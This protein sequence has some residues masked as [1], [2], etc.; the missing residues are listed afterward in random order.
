MNVDRVNE[1]NVSQVKTN[2]LPITVFKRPASEHRKS[3]LNYQRFNEALN[4]KEEVYCYLCGEPRGD[5]VD[6]RCRSCGGPLT[7]QHENTFSIQRIATTRFSMWRYAHALAPSIVCAPVSLGEGC[8]P[9]VNAIRSNIWM[10]LEHVMPTLSFKD[11]GSAA[12]MSYVRSFAGSRN[13]RGVS[14]DSSGNAGASIAAYAS[15]AGL[16]CRIFAPT[17]ISEHKERQI[18]ALGA[19]LEKLSGSRELITQAATSADSGFIYVGHAWNP[20]FIEGIKTL[21]YELAE[22][23]RWNSPDVIYVPVSA[24][25]ILLGVIYGF[26]HLLESG[27]VERMP[28]IVAVQPRS[29]SPLYYELRGEKYDTSQ[30]RVGVADALTVARPP[31]LSEMVRELTIVRGEVRIVSDEEILRAHR[32]LGLMG[33][34]VEPSSAVGY[35]AL[36]REIDE[37]ISSEKEAVVI[38]T[39]AGLKTPR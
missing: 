30:F 28:T 6:W 31:R 8:T 19:R 7:L 27:A 34:H 18:Q 17:T 5:V 32:E 9:L 20:Y 36:R 35:A 13:I 38:L 39:G 1:R 37:I 12:L 22:Q 2:L 24:G 4:V 14:E 26:K 10:K 33:F 16:E 3:Q 25:T 11:R 29:M 23:F 15:Y 21:A